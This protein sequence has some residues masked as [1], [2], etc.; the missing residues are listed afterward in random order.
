MM[1][2][3]FLLVLTVLCSCELAPISFAVYAEIPD[4]DLKTVSE[5]IQ[6]TAKNIEYVSEKS[7]ESD[8]QN[9][10]VTYWLQTGDCED[11]ATLAMYLIHR[12]G[13]DSRMVAGTRL[14][15]GVKHCWLETT[16]DWWEPQSGHRSNYYA[17]TY[18]D[19]KYYD[20]DYMLGE[21]ELGG[22]AR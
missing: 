19:I 18:K 1:G 13:I 8:W 7:G 22:K 3:I 16:G 21:Y 12:L 5:V 9:P 20:Y 17:K 2:T 15:D 6:W 14:A 10:G 4:L 11:F